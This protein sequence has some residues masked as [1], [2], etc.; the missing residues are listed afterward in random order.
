MSGEDFENCIVDV[1]LASE[2][3]A[4][5]HQSGFDTVVWVVVTRPVDDAVSSIYSEMSKHGVVLSLDIVQKAAK[6]RGCLYVSSAEYNYIF[7]L[8][9]ARFRERFRR[10]VSGQVVDYEF[11][12]F[13]MDH[14]GMILLRQLLPEDAFT[15]FWQLAQISQRRENVRLSDGQIETNYAATALGLR[16]LSR[17]RFARLLLAPFTQ[18]RLRKARI[19]KNSGAK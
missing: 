1:A 16:R 9:F 6:E 7:V 4:L 12:C 8:D 13:I 11:D 19:T 17:K 2:I 5:A 15:R 3:E 14:P 10:H 18:L